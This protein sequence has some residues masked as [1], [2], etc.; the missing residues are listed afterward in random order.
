MATLIPKY[1]QVTTS[2]RTIAQ[3]FAETISVLDFG[4]TG[5]GSTDDSVAIQAAI[6]TGKAVYFPAGTYKC[7]V[8]INNR[9]ILF[10]DGSTLSK[11]TPFSNASAAFLYT[12][13]AM[14]TPSPLSFWNYHSVVRDLGFYGSSATSGGSI[15]F[16]FGT[17]SPTVYTTNAEL[18]NN[19]QFYDCFFS[20]NYIG[21]Q[22]P[23]GNI[24]S[25]FYSCGFASN[26][27]GVYTV[28]NKSGSGG[29]MHAGCKYFYNGEFHSNT[30]AVYINN[31]TEGFG[32]VEFTDTIF[33]LNN[34]VLW[35]NSTIA[36]SFVPVT[37]KNCW[38]ESNGSLTYTLGNVT[39]DSWSG[40]T[41]TTQS[42]SNLQPWVIGADTTI[43]DSCF[44]TGVKL[45]KSNSQ[46]YVKNSRVENQA[47][48]LGAVITVTG[49]NSRIYLENTFS[50]A[51][52]ISDTN[53]IY[54]GVNSMT[55]PDVTDTFYAGPRARI[56][57]LSYNKIS[58][59]NKG[60]GLSLDFTT[61]QAYTGTSSGTGTVVSDGVKY[62]SC[63]E[64]T[65]NFTASNQYIIFTNTANSNAT[66]WWATT[67]DVK[68]TASTASGTNFYVWDS[69][70]NQ[71]IF[72]TIPNDSRWHT[73]GGVGYYPGPSAA[74]SQLWIGGAVN[75]TTFRVSAYQMI[76]FST[77]SDAEEFIASRTYL[78]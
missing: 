67:I 59:T 32:A 43:F 8:T 41:R 65:Y 25:A 57:P 35:F 14:S 50:N 72:K 60:T 27:Y 31:Q 34:L 20:N 53:V 61:A 2:N 17:N 22:F 24:G 71:F 9:T 5:N 54:T 47:A 38:N 56:L 68:V 16:S 55:R 21:V 40:T 77:R 18:A 66:G 26:Y 39:I 76:P 62:T 70:L 7:N 51:A 23:L 74:T 13:T 44:F 42:V 11:I 1:T 48:N 3:K 75:N 37:F 4:A 12:Y 36:A 78:A 29:V 63:N 52:N 46:I 49:T 73:I 64:V 30:C 58:G 28:D 19:V 69:N 33:E 45:T 10:G 6:N 15:G